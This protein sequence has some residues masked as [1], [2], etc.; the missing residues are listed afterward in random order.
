ML[1]WIYIHPND[2]KLI[3]DYASKNNSVEEYIIDDFTLMID[4]IYL[5]HKANNQENQ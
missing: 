2:F 3:T 1:D 4:D 5:I